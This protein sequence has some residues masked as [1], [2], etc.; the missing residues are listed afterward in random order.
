VAWLNATAW[1]VGDYLLMPD[2]LH[3]FC[4]PRDIDM[5]IETWIRYWKRDFAINRKRLAGTLAHQAQ[6][7]GNSNREGGIIVCVTEKVIRRNGGMFKRIL[8]G[9]GL[10]AGSKI[11]SS[12]EKFLIWCGM[13]NN[14]RNGTA[15]ADHSIIYFL[16]GSGKSLTLGQ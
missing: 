4:A 6:S 12:K 13:E 10:R 8:S 14:H 5:P 7:I 16:A 11:G 1:L 9:K 3:L 15:A 2:H